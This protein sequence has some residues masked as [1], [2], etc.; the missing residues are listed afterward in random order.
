MAGIAVHGRAIEQ[1][2]FWNVIDRFRQGARSTLRDIAA[3]VAGL[4]GYRRDHAVIHGGASKT[5]LRPVARIA[6]GYAAHD[7]YVRC[8]LS[9]GR[10]TVVAV[11]TGARTY[12]VRGRV[13]ENDCQPAC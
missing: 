10:C 4:A 5:G 13:S 6:L 3:V 12:C 2:H 8:R 7:R 9:S 1:L 11:V